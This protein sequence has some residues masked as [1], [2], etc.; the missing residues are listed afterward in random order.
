MMHGS[1]GTDGRRGLFVIGLPR[2]GTTVL[3]NL[4]DQHPQ[5]SLT[6]YESHFIPR[7][8]SHLETRS[9]WHDPAELRAIVDILWSSTLYEDGRRRDGLSL[10]RQEL[11]Q[12]VAGARSAA[13]LV[14]L[15][16]SPFLSDPD[17]SL[18][19]G[20]KTPHYLNHIPLINRHVPGARYIHIIRDPR[21]QA[22]SEARA[23]RKSPVRSAERWRAAISLTRQ[24]VA[25]TRVSYREVRYEDLVQAPRATLASLF[26]WMQ[27]DDEPTIGLTV[28]NSDELGQSQGRTD[29]HQDA[30]G[31]RRE[32]ADPKLIRRIESLTSPLCVE[33]G[34]VEEA[35]PERFG[36]LEARVLAAADAL[37]LLGYDV[38]SRGLRSGLIASFFRFREK[39]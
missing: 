9:N 38:R 8:L 11:S 15:S 23:W 32:D 35:A 28:R 36:M 27:L 24:D 13:E 5:V 26:E 1:R 30:V 21:D 22:L 3:R 25:A 10:T 33:L 20:D 37:A 14:L 34:Y 17:N 2:S 39:A 6:R 18:Y 16:L 4:L 12:R 29:V 7:L 31:S 19:W